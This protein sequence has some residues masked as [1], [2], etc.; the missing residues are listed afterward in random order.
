MRH[1]FLLIFHLPNKHEDPRVHSDMLNRIGINDAEICWGIRGH[2]GLEL[3]RQ[4]RSLM[5]AKAQAIHQVKAA[6]PGATLM[7]CVD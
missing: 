1:K 6:I 3:Y 4:G 2:L 7:T 5:D